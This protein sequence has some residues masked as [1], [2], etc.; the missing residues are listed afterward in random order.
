[1]RTYRLIKIGS[2][3]GLTMTEDE[4]PS[5][6]H[7]EVLVKIRATSLNFR[8]LAILQGW[9]PFGV[10]EGRVPLSDAAGE[11]VSVG[12]GVKR[13][14]AGDHV[15]NSCIPAWY[16]GSLQTLPDQYGIH[17]DGWSTDYKVIDEQELVRMPEYLTFEEAATL[18]CAAMTAWSALAQAGPGD[19]VLTQ[20]TGGVSLF[21]V[22]LA[23]A[24]GATVL[25]TTSSQEKAERLKALGADH[26]INYRATP[27]WGDQVRSLTGG[28]G[29]TRIVEVGGPGTIAQSLRAV[30]IGG[31]VSI[32]GVLAAGEPAINFMDMFMSQATIQP[33]ATGSRRD[34]EDLLRVMSQHLIRP[35]VDSVYSMADA[36]AAWTHFGDRQLFGKV[37]ISN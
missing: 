6:G 29:V 22:Q 13:F 12:D 30:A 16:G 10:Q 32:V 15:I 31:Q 26:V 35:V 20:G 4:I 33:I 2:L 5:P 27:E 3:D 18:P 8:D 7:G 28:Q 21:A 14:K 37:V 19:T 23:K 11:V 9:M 36:K 1:M 25:A 34:L 24:A 17:V